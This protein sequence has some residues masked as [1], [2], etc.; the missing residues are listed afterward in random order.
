MALSHR[1]VARE[2]KNREGEPSNLRRTLLRVLGF[3]I[4]GTLCW[5]AL[6]SA[7]L[8]ALQAL[9]AIPD[10]DACGLAAVLSIL[11]LVLCGLLLARKEIAAAYRSGQHSDAG[12]P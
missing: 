10:E 12:R 8:L 4:V 9:T 7:A 1:A 2:L 3:T 6:F 5:A 11:P